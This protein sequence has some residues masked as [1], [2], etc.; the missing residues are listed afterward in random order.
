MVVTKVSNESQNSLRLYSQKEVGDILELDY[1]AI[2][3]LCSYG[4]I[5]TV[6]DFVS[7]RFLG[8]TE[9][10]LKRLKAMPRGRGEG[11]LPVGRK[12]K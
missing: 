2:N 1:P 9:E 8:I 11:H 3:R 5:N 4:A 12:D 7:N 10:E 6:R